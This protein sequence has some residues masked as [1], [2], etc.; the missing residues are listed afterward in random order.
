MA[1]MPSL[2]I[3]R[4]SISYTRGEVSVTF[5]VSGSKK[6]D[7]DIVSGVE[8]VELVYIG[9]VADGKDSAVHRY[10]LIVK[11]DEPRLTRIGEAIECA[12]QGNQ[13][14]YRELIALCA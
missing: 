6:L 4:G 7:N 5:G 13:A 14:K 12:I 10:R 3:V 2:N 11:G 9:L 8:G 1:N